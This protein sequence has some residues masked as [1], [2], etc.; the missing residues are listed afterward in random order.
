VAAMRLVISTMNYSLNQSAHQSAAAGKSQR[1]ACHIKEFA[2]A[3][4]LCPWDPPHAC[5][6]S[7]DGAHV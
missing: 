5:F 3:K 7:A 2:S 1:P 4:Q 6:L